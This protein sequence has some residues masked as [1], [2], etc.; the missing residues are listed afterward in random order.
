MV[1][2]SRRPQPAHDQPA[3]ERELQ[4]ELEPGL[5]LELEPELQLE[6]EPGLEF[7]LEPELQLELEPELQSELQSELE[8][9]QQLELE[10]ELELEQQLQQQLELELQLELQLQ[11]ELEL[12]LELELARPGSC[13]MLR[14]RPLIEFLCRREDKGVIAEP[15]PAK[16]VLPPWFRH[17]PGIDKSQ[18]SATNNGLTVKR[19]PPFLDAMTAGWIIPLAATV[20]LEISDGGE[21]VNA[22]WEFDRELV[23]THAPFQVAGGPHVPRP[24]MKFNNYWTI[25]TPKGW[26]SL[27]LPPVNRP[28]GVVEVVSGLVDTDTYRS[29]VNFPFF[30]IAPDGVYTLEKGTPLVQVIPVRRADLALRASIRAENEREAEERERIRR[31]THTAAGWYKRHARAAR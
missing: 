23:S 3:V 2:L 4:P 12:E 18:L 11:L 5:E 29:P 14:R 21:T 1:A 30:A 17:L 19:C 7:E 16:G 8:P 22:G 10:L 27:F 20:R 9:E 15:V 26:S 13:V 24:P 25:R 28:N 6:L 31:S